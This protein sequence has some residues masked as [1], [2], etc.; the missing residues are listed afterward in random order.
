MQ[1]LIKET[2]ILEIGDVSVEFPISTIQVYRDFIKRGLKKLIFQK[3]SDQTFFLSN[4]YSFYCSGIIQNYSSEG[5]FC[6]FTSL[7]K[8]GIC[9]Q[10]N[11]FISLPRIK[12][13][14]IGAKLFYIES[15]SQTIPVTITATDNLNEKHTV[16]RPHK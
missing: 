12:I 6:Y 5:D 10:E 2:L 8:F 11:H 1:R 15:L 7:N 9:L 4:G 13:G 16:K 14:N 3:N